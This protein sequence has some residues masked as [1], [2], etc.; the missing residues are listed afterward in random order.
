MSIVLFLYSFVFYFVLKDFNFAISTFC[1]CVFILYTFLI[2]RKYYNIKLLIHGYLIF[3]PLFAAFIMLYFW[4]F[5]AATAFWLLPVPLGAHIFLEK[6]FVYIYS[7]YILIIIAS[8]GIMNKFF[9]FTYFSLNNIN[10]IIISDTFVGI[11]NIGVVCLLLYYNEKIKKLE[12]KEFYTNRQTEPIS[13]ENPEPETITENP[14]TEDSE[15]DSNSISSEEMEKF[16]E[17]FQK[18]KEAVEERNHFKE[19]DFTISRLSH[20]INVNNLYISKAI[21]VSGYSNFNHYLNVCRI[22][23]VKKLIHENDINK[24]TLMYIYTASGFSNQSTF[25]RVF[26]QI[27]GITPSEY[28]KSLEN[29]LESE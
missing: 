4:R 14:D 5:S 22:E 10:S 7:A 9:S 20:I 29:T 28:L 12:L 23:N 24:V 13:I 3:A 11:T 27:E 17:I 18:I 26:K 6:K 1:F 15:K 25:N 16:N 8:V 2:I 21:K 19:D